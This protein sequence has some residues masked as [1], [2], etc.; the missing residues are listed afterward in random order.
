MELPGLAGRGRPQPWARRT[1]AILFSWG[2]R[3]L[4]SKP[5]W[6]DVSTKGET[7]ALGAH[8][9]QPLGGTAWC[10]QD[11]S[12]WQ[13]DIET[14][15]SRP[16]QCAWGMQVSVPLELAPWVGAGIR[17]KQGQRCWMPSLSRDWGT[18]QSAEEGRL[19]VTCKFR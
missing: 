18:P 16:E 15:R 2:S 1:Q 14:H 12:T 10:S 13:K 5:K 4:K 19:A 3:Y 9:S 17:G 8:G 11:L 7:D 6:K